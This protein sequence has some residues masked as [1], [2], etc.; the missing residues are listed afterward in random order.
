VRKHEAILSYNRKNR[1]LFFS[2][3]GVIYA[4]LCPA[5][6]SGSA[7]NNL[8]PIMVALHQNYSTRCHAQ[9]VAATNRVTEQ[10]VG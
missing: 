8:T 4:Y 7:L 3:A 10:L 2:S 5:P 1:R 6:S 9:L